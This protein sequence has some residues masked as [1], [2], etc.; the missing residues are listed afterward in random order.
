MEDYTMTSLHHIR[1]DSSFDDSR[2]AF[3]LLKR[4]LLLGSNAL[5][6][7]IF[8]FGATVYAVEIASGIEACRLPISGLSPLRFAFLFFD[9]GP[10]FRGAPELA[11]A[12][13]LCTTR[14]R[15]A[16]D[17]RIMGRIHATAKK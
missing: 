5:S 2:R 10:L 3:M 12:S 6:A 17:R 16:A 11:L 7:E 14:S 13:A 8:E 15:A 4:E 9:P 1:R